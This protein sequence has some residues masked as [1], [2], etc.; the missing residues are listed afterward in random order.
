MNEF[1]LELSGL[2]KEMS[3][4]YPALISGPVS[5]RFHTHADRFLLLNYLLTELMASKMCH[6]IKPLERVVIEIV[7]WDDMM[8]WMY[9][10]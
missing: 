10:I 8:A 9:F 7:S 6:K 5:N 2:L 4:P 3:C 1:L